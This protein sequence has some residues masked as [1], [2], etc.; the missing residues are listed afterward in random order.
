M[1]RADIAD[2]EEYEQSTVQQH[3]Y[4]LG[5]FHFSQLQARFMRVVRYIKINTRSLK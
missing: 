1:T 3:S 4:K 5:F 2:I